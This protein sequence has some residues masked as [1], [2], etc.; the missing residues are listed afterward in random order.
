MDG[1]INSVYLEAIDI[2]L[3]TFVLHMTKRWVLKLDI[4]GIYIWG[5]NE[6]SFNIFRLIY[7][8][9]I[10]ILLIATPEKKRPLW[11]E[12][13]GNIDI[14]WLSTKASRMRLEIRPSSPLPGTSVMNQHN[15]G[16]P[17]SDNL[18][19]GAKRKGISCKDGTRLRACTLGG[20]S[21]RRVPLVTN[22]GSRNLRGE[23]NPS[24]SS[25]TEEC[26][27]R[28][29]SPVLQLNGITTM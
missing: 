4:N 2:Y 17:G 19:R 1:V 27:L 6:K 11:M 14:V 26:F 22:S 10:N 13:A 18:T 8:E 21:L 3:D 5:A 12:Y 25:A 20:S 23:W 24:V 9:E 28:L 15:Q 7:F 16:Q 29:D